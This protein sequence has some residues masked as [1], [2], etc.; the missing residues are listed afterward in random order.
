[1]WCGKINLYHAAAILVIEAN[2]FAWHW[3]APERVWTGNQKQRIYS[4]GI[5][6]NHSMIKVYTSSLYNNHLEL[7]LLYRLIHCNLSLQIP[8]S[9]C[10]WL[11]GGP[12]GINLLF[13]FAHQH[14]FWCSL[15]WGSLLI[16]SFVSVQYGC[17][18]VIS[19]F[20]LGTNA[21]SWWTFIHNIA[22][23]LKHFGTEPKIEIF[24]QCYEWS[25]IMILAQVWHWNLEET[26]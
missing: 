25:C 12:R 13:S 20:Y 21:K 6:T 9:C 2:D 16:K 5:T 18:V 7:H 19:C 11:C 8:L 15:V 24:F 3:G 23:I 17:S 26:K 14:F 4:H 10:G 22:C 1:L